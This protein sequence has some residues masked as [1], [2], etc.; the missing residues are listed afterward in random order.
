MR[1]I[2]SPIFSP[3]PSSTATFAQLPRSF[4]A[5]SSTSRRNFSRQALYSANC[6]LSWTNSSVSAATLAFIISCAVSFCASLSMNVSI[7]IPPCVLGHAHP[8]CYPIFTFGSVLVFHPDFMFD[9]ILYSIIF[10]PKRQVDNPAA[11]RLTCAGCIL[12]TQFSGVSP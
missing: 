9:P 11:D 2:S 10:L 7:C 8:S 6:F 1:V 4:S 12:S 5:P 3:D